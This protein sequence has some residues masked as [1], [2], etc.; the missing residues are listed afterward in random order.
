MYTWYENY[1]GGINNLVIVKSHNIVTT[2]LKGMEVA[3]YNHKRKLKK[4]GILEGIK[5]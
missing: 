3:V 1:K 4:L 5:C 2:S